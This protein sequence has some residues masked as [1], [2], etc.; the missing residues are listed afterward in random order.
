MI[1][2]VQLVS[3]NKHKVIQL[4]GQLA[5]KLVLKMAVATHCL[6]TLENVTFINSR[7]YI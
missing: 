5:K 7:N 3:C 4:R 1:L 6:P 2:T